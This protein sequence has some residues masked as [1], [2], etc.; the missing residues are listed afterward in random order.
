MRKLSSFTLNSGLD[1]RM[2]ALSTRLIS[3]YPVATKYE[4]LDERGKL[5]GLDYDGEYSVS[6]GTVLTVGKQKY[7]ISEVKKSSR[8]TTGYELYT[9]RKITTT[10]T[11][12]LPFLGKDRSFWRW[13][14]E[15]VNA[16]I[17]D[18]TQSDGS[19]IHILYRFSG[20][21]SFADFEFALI[22]LPGYIESVD[23][24]KY[25]TLYKFKLPE[26]YKDDIQLIMQGNYSK[27]SNTG[28]NRIMEFH[29][30]NRTKAIGQILYKSRER[31][32]KIE[33]DINSKLPADAE[34]LDMFDV[35]QEIF[36]NKFKIVEHNDGEK[37]NSDFE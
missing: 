36:K 31:R 21:K 3:M 23:T 13:S 2:E 33:R 19:E 12:I 16:F 22:D 6:E 35:S 25:H 32:E 5:V 30:S 15:F 1:I 20:N 14:L 7:K 29:N 37:R 10:G 4:V 18:E 34:L 24:D 8:S 27:I 9:F 11:F 28:K 17:G 26:A